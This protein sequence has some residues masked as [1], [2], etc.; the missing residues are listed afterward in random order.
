MATLNVRL[1]V[2]GTRALVKEPFYFKL[3]SRKAPLAGCLV[4]AACQP[5]F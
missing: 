5:P 1:S 2:R 3:P 4:T